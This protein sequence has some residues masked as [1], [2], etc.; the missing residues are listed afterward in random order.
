MSGQSHIEK[1]TEHK[2]WLEFLTIRIDFLKRITLE[3]QQK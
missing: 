1:S 2:L 3:E